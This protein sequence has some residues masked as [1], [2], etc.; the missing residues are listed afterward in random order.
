MRKKHKKK[1]CNQMNHLLEKLCCEPGRPSALGGVNKL[2]RATCRYGV[3][4][5][6]VLCWLQQQPAY[7]LHRPAR[8]HFRRN[9]VVVNDID[10]QW[11]AA[12]VDMQ[13]LSRWNR[14][15]KYLLTCI[16]ILSKYT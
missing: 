8:K 11:K 4:R 15:Y 5:S 16:D 9:R 12:L 14:K 3:K 10:S 1:I 6:Q 7:T 13:S 2:Y